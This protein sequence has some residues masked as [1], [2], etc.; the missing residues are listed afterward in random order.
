[1]ANRS[2]L[3]VLKGEYRPSPKLAVPL[4]SSLHPATTILSQVVKSSFTSG[5]SK[6]P[7]LEVILPPSSLIV[8]Y[9]KLPNLQLLLCPNDQNKLATN[10]PPGSVNGYMDTDCHCMVCQASLFSK[11]ISPPSMPGY[12]LKI[13]ETT[14]CGS[15][16]HVIYHLSCNSG[17]QHC[18]K[19]HYTGRA[20]SSNPAKNPWL[21]DGLTIRVT[22]ITT[23]SSVPSHPI[24]YGSIE[25]KTPNSLSLS[26]FFNQLLTWKWP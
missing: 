22:L 25:K 23:M 14:H 2:R 4:V 5:L 13:P 21:A 1:M 6:D 11:W 10:A 3:K 20:S 16:P 12:S 24:F 17:S 26:R 19:A 9:T 8:A 18:V 7:V 15:G